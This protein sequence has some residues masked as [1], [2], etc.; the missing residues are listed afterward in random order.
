[1]T[2]HSEQIN[3]YLEQEVLSASPLRLRWMLIRR[4]EELCIEVER[5]WL[6]G[7][8]QQANGWLIRI[9]EIIGE[10]LDGVRDNDN[11][12]SKPVSDFYVFL[13]KLLSQLEFHRDL[14]Q[15][16]TLT[17]LLHVES[18]TWEAVVKKFSGKD[19]YAAEAI[20]SGVLASVSTLATEAN[21]PALGSNPS[22]AGGLGTSSLGSAAGHESAEFRL[23][24]S[25]D[26]LMVSTEGLNLE[27]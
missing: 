22:G 7:D 18:E 6:D 9:R 5:L 20:L 16:K 1:M 15:L 10:L 27:A 3:P 19:Q 25:V 11:P 12:V 21:V 26:E 13:L 14:T 4:A 17:E 8:D 24:K 23:L 2:P